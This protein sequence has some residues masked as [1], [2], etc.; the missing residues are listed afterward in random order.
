M[1]TRFA[2]SEHG[3]IGIRTSRVPYVIH[4]L[5]GS[6]L[7]K[8]T[9]EG[10]RECGRKKLDNTVKYRCHSL[11][12]GIATVSEKGMVKEIVTN[13]DRYLASSSFDDR[14]TQI[15]G[16]I[17]SQVSISKIHSFYYSL[18]FSLN[19]IHLAIFEGKWHRKFLL[20]Q[21]IA[22]YNPLDVDRKI[23]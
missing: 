13:N 10:N 4:C 15:L 16:I 1:V 11:E 8:T 20:K 6:T 2:G 7:E 14:G 22:N 21:N 23:L 18:N 19:F 9:R 17:V 12:E 3:T 5:P